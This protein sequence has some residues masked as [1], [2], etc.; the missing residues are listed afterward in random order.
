MCDG[1]CDGEERIA[2][3]EREGVEVKAKEE[4]DVEA[5][6]A[7]DIGNIGVRVEV[8]RLSVGVFEVELAVDVVEHRSVVARLVDRA[9]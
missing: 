1:F 3:V 4:V 6:S 7:R 8:E 9:T 2:A 5:N